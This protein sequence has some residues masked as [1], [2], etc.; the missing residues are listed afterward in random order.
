MPMSNKPRITGRFMM[1]S[2]VSVLGAI[3]FLPSIL[4][5]AQPPPPLP[6]LSV[7]VLVVSAICMAAAW[8]GLRLADSTHLPMPLLRRLDMQSETSRDN[9]IV[10][11][12]VCGGIFAAAAIGFLH[13]FHQQNLAGSFASRLAS[14]LFAAGKLLGCY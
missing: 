3:A 10:P 5:S 11:A 1:L 7:F 4:A 12:T 9:G 13:Y 6:Q 2:A 8:F 14:V